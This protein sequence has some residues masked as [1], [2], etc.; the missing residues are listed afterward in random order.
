MI[1]TYLPKII[2][3]AL[4]LWV[5]VKFIL[6][7]FEKFES[8]ERFAGRTS[9]FLDFYLAMG[10]TGYMMPLLGVVEI[11]GGV[12]LISQR[13]SFIGALMLLPVM[14]NVWLAH[15]FL[16]QS[17]TG[18]TLTSLMFAAMLLFVV[19]EWKRLR[20]LIQPQSLSLKAKK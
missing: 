16:I 6:E 8:L 13:Y 2:L 18:I 12:L 9:P 1:K 11:L 15:T 17:P 3:I 10:E 7:G 4:K 5:G 20:V 14:L 19:L